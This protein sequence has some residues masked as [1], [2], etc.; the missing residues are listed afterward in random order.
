MSINFKRHSYDVGLSPLNLKSSKRAEVEKQLAEHIANRPSYHDIL[1]RTAW[2]QKKDL[3][4]V[5]LAFSK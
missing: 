4:E 1:A 5:E 2:A 3:L